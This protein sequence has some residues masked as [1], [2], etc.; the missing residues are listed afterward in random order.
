MVI[1]FW[2]LCTHCSNK[3]KEREVFEKTLVIFVA[4]VRKSGA[5]TRSALVL[6]LWLCFLV[7][8]T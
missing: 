3:R 7:F 6:L 5:L 8:V 1:T 2:L 4:I